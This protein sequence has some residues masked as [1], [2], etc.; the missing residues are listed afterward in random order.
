MKKLLFIALVGFMTLN[1][2]GLMAQQRPD[3]KPRQEQVE[4]LT[5]KLQPRQASALV[6]TITYNVSTAARNVTMEDN[7]DILKGYA[8]EDKHASTL[9][10][11]VNSSDYLSQMR[12]LHGPDVRDENA[13]TG[14]QTRTAPR[15]GERRGRSR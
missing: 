11:A 1:F 15:C 14:Q 12:L 9:Y 13:T 7:D 6:S 3:R 10:A 4:T 8:G 2:S 5:T